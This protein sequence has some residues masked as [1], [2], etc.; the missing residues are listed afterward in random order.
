[1]T[2][3]LPRHVFANAAICARSKDRRLCKQ[4]LPPPYLTSDGLIATDRRSHLDRRASWLRE[5]S[6]D[7]GLYG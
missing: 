3:D 6:L 7:I 1:M 2:Q 4:I 5:Y